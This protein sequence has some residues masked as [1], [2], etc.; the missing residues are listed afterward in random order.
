MADFRIVP[1]WVLVPPLQ[2]MVVVVAAGTA[3]VGDVEVEFALRSEFFV[4]LN[5]CGFSLLLLVAPLL[6]FRDDFCIFAENT[7]FGKED[8]E[9]LINEFCPAFAC[10]FC[11]LI[12]PP[13]SKLAPWHSDETLLLEDSLRPGNAVAEVV[14]VL[15]V[16]QSKVAAERGLLLTVPVVELDESQS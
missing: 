1:P 5:L 16:L 9:P 11:C 13:L 7:L 6:L 4:S 14:E 12:C 3:M 10:M 8:D 2:L 15:L